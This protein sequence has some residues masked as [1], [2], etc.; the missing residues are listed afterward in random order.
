MR[1]AAEERFRIVHEGEIALL[2]K[3]SGRLLP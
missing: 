1:A 2:G 3:L